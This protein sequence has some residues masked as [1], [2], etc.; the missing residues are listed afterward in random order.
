MSQASKATGIEKCYEIIKNN[1]NQG[2]SKHEKLLLRV[3]YI[4]NFYEK[5][6]L[7][8]CVCPDLSICRFD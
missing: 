7:L 8:V 5:V 6:K 3:S 2:R 1:K 4:L